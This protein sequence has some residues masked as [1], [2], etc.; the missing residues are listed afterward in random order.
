M[1]RHLKC[2]TTKS[3]AV[4]PPPLPPAG[5]PYLQHL[6]DGQTSQAGAVSAARL[7][8]K[9]PVVGLGLLQAGVEDVRAAHVHRCPEE[10]LG[11]GRRHQGPH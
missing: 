1:R 2:V 10:T 3:R 4:T 7:L 6:V 5:V 9:H 8:Q 11:H